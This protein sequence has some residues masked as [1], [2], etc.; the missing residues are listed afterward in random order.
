MLER[1]RLTLK[2]YTIQIAK[3]KTTKKK[4]ATT[5]TF[6]T[7][8]HALGNMVLRGHRAFVLCFA[9]RIRVTCKAIQ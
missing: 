9:Q 4:Q 7:E 5:L 3:K 6:L 2:S 1:N 8:I